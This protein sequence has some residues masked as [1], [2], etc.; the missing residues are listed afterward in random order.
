[1]I[2]GYLESRLVSIGESKVAKSLQRIAPDHYAVRRCRTTDRTNPR[3]Y[4]A[5]CFGHKLHLD[6]NEKLVIFGV[7]HVIAVDGYSGKIVS[8]N[9][10]AVKNN[11]IIY[12]KV[13]R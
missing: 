12:D 6:Q 13:W 5:R 10:S 9:T 3:P 1:M 8:Y 11:L 4:Y 2:K 7:T